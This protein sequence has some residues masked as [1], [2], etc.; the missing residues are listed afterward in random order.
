MQSLKALKEAIEKYP[1]ASIYKMLNFYSEN[2]D[3]RIFEHIT[4]EVL[5]LNEDD[6]DDCFLILK[7]KHVLPDG[8]T[9]DCYV[10]MFL[11]TREWPDT[12]YFKSE[13]MFQSRP[14]HECEGDI[15]CAVPIDH[16]GVYEIFYS[17]IAPELSIS[18]LKRGL[19][20]MPNSAPIAEDLGYILRDEGRFGE[21][22]AAFRISADG[23][24]PSASLIYGEIAGC[25]KEIGDID[26][27]KKY[28]DLV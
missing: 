12:V 18:I 4:G 3:E 25:Y 23:A 10:D 27:A 22:V 26:K 21:A 28:Y 20:V 24:G 6:A 7:A 16:W 2:E 11:P 15:V 1:S 8:T 9:S 13:D 5:S 17:K 19:E 14:T